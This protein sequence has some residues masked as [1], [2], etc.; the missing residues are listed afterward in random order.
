MALLW[1]LLLIGPL[2]CLH[3]LGH[4]VTARLLGIG[5]LSISFGMGKK[6][7]SAT[8]GGTEWSIRLFPIGGYVHLLGE[9]EGDTVSAANRRASFAERPPW[10]R[11]AVIMGG[12]AANI[13]CA[14]PLF[15]AIY[16][17]HQTALASEIGTVFPGFPAAEADLRPG[18]RVVAVDG[19]PVRYWE[20]LNQ[21][22]LLSPGRE[23]KLTIER[24]GGPPLEKYVRPREHLSPEAASSDAP[25]GLIG[26]APHRRLPQIGIVSERSPA[27]LAGMKTFDVVLAIQGRPAESLSDLE[28]LVSPRSGGMLVVSYVRPANSLGFAAVGRLEPAEATVV[29]SLDPILA[30]PIPGADERDRKLVLGK[31]RYDA[32]VR[33]ADL[34]VYDVEVG[35]VASG[36]GLLRGDQ[37]LRLDDNA[38]G[39]WELFERALEERPTAEHEIAWFRPGSGAVQHARFTLRADGSDSRALHFGAVGPQALEPGRVIEVDHRIPRALGRAIERTVSISLLIA[40]TLV[41]IITGSVGSSA[42]GGPIRLVAAAGEAAQQGGDPFLAMAALVSLNLGLINLLPL[43]LL[44]GGQAALVLVEGLAGREVSARTRRRATLI[45]LVILVAILLFASWNDLIHLMA[46]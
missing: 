11:L 26:I 37:L 32:G 35:S 29:P 46:K 6:L 7:L 22:V 3:E 36:I 5:V 40:R 28:P 18:D 17:R 31:G 43:P 2:V 33:P 15:F 19:E 39:S 24:Q 27:G 8:W 20:E 1:F 16:A 21:R 14:I 23:L 13:L 30:S 38:L 45:G 9:R 42:I 34:F 4:L 10:Q 41:G 25:V 12:P 44:D